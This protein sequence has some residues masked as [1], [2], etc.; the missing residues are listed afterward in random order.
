MT[1]IAKLQD[2]ERAFFGNDYLT[3]DRVFTWE[4]GRDVHP[5]IIRQRFD[6]LACRCGL[7]H[8][9]LHDVR[10][11]SARLGC[12]AEDCQRSARPRLAGVTARVYQHVLPA[13]DQDA[14]H[15]IAAL[16][17]DPAEGPG[18]AEDGSP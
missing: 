13:M 14:A 17:V 1:G 12:P 10:H 18:T 11:G 4:D 3:T 2:Q 15:S 16:M 9:R 5:D 7:P 8:I 6:R